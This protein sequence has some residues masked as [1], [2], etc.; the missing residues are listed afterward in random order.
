MPVV[1]ATW[2]TEV[3]ESLE[4]EKC[5]LR[6][7]APLHCSLGDSETLLPHQKKLMQQWC[8]E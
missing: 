8:S 1:S 5:G 3:E 6:G 4:P 7:A 2:E